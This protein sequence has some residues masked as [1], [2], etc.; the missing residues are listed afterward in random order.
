MEH[1]LFSRSSNQTKNTKGFSPLQSKTDER[2]D[3]PILV[4]AVVFQFFCGAFL[5]FSPDLYTLTST[6]ATTLTNLHENQ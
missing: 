4:H 6:N 5:G 2:A 1:T 3:A